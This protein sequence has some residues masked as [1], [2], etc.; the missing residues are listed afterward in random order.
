MKHFQYLIKLYL[1]IVFIILFHIDN[2]TLAQVNN[3]NPEKSIT[4]YSL[5]SWTIDDG[6]PSNALNDVFQSKNGY[7]WIATHSGVT[8]FD[9]INFTNYAIKNTKTMRTDAIR[10]ICED[11]SGLIWIGTQKGILQFRNNKLYRNEKLKMLDNSNIERIF[12]DKNNAVWI[13]TNANGLFKYEADS[14]IMMKDFHEIT[15]SSVFAICQDNKGTLWIGTINGELIKY[16]DNTFIPYN[17]QNITA[18]IYSL[19]QDKDGTI[20]VGASRGVFSLEN[21]QLKKHDDIEILFVDHIAEDQNGLL[22]FASSSLG[23]YRYN[24]NLHK[25]ERFSEK[26]G[27]PNNRVTKIIFDSQGNLWGTTYRKGLFQLTDGKFTCYSKSEGLTSNANTAILQY[28]ENEFWIANEMGTIDILRNKKVEKLKTQIPIPSPQIKNMFKDSRGNVWISTY[29]GILKVGKNKERLFNINTGFPD[30]YIRLTFEDNNGNIWVAT[31]RAGLHK[32]KLD[33]RTK[34]LNINNG[35]STN[36]VM[37]ITQYTENIIIAGTKKGI[38]F[39]KND[40]VIKKYTMTDGL[41]DNMIFNLYKDNKNILWISTNSGIS[42]FDGNEFINYSIE[43]GLQTNTIFDILEDNSGNFWLPGPQGIMKVEKQQLNEYAAGKIK[44]IEYT[45]YDKSDGMKS[46]VCLG[47]TQS[48]KDTKGNL[49]FLTAEGV[50]TINPENITSSEIL[51]SVF[52]EK[53]YALDSTYELKE[54]INILPKHKRLYINFTAIDL[55]YPEKIQFK[56]KLEPFENNWVNLGNKRDVS[57]TNIDPGNYTFKL[58]STNSHGVWNNEYE[59]LKITILPAW[60]QTLLF[61]IGIISFGLGLILLAYKVR[62]NRIKKQRNVLETE[63]RKRTREIS[64]QKEEIYTQSEEIKAQRDFAQKQNKKIEKQNEELENH[65]NH[66]EDIVKKRTKE[67]EKAKEKAEESDMLKSAFLANMSHEIRTPMNAI[68]GFSQLLTEENISDSDKRRFTAQIS[69]SAD[70]LLTLINDILDLAKIESNEIT[71]NKTKFELCSLLEE[72]IESGLLLNKK[73]N[74]NIELKASPTK[75][76]INSDRIRIAQVLLNLLSNAYKFTEEGS[77]E[78]GYKLN[79][80]VLLI[81]VK[82][83]GI[84]ISKENIEII[85]DRFRKVGVNKSRLFRGVGLGLTISKK[86]ALLLGGDLLV[87][88]EEGK[89]S[90]FSLLLPSDCIEISL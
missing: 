65:R 56:C 36:Y 58:C 73:D 18:G 70:S 49:W 4:Q 43:T 71:I 64:Q 78:I 35:L 37:A 6:L 57:Y 61:K 26:N 30:D 80:S 27:L 7:I 66:L 39:I 40:S 22:W 84:G 59:L 90:T 48:L 11:K 79:N 13:G 41:P 55:T 67:L 34:T 1:I 87:E 31:N 9:G 69:E 47:A 86:I 53:V 3:L 46:S 12:V 16:Q 62:I 83:T 10:R 17:M 72:I 88:S 24:K 50:A 8:R 77:I 38:N 89:G 42:R 21:N 60:H 44:K 75:I 2:K 29:N 19:H 28:N 76:I 45:F 52:I 68:V 63:V 23:L 54:R 74:L 5:K 81:F 82:D 20:W 33:G 51:P 85:F 14:L 15:T 25:I 32:L